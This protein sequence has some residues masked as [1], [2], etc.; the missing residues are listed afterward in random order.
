MMDIFIHYGVFKHLREETGAK[1]WEPI[2]VILLDV[3]VLGAFL[4]VKASPIC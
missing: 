1:P 2:S 4:W 3:T